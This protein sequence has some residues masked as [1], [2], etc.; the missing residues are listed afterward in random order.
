MTESQR[1]AILI[2]ALRLLPDTWVTKFNDRSTGGIPDFCII[3]G[4]TTLWFECKAGSKVTRLQQETLK[5]IGPTAHVIIWE[6]SRWEIRDYL[7][8]FLSFGVD[9]RSLVATIS[10]RFEAF[11]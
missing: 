8:G 3:R 1:T 4:N 5:R 6:K 11:K 10:Q 2:K 7:Q 9:T